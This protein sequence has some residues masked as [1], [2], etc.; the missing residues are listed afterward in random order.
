MDHEG[1]RG[2]VDR[3]EK[4]F[5]VYCPVV[6]V[7]QIVCHDPEG[8]VIIVRTHGVPHGRRRRAPVVLRIT[9]L[10]LA[11]EAVIIPI[12]DYIHVY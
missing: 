8:D 5:V 12:V 1:S 6:H 3:V 2:V 9:V 4:D 7:A 11:M 10:V